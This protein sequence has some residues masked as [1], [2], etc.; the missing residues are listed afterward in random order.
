MIVTL[1]CDGTSWMIA[2]SLFG[3]PHGNEIAIIAWLIAT[4]TAVWI[5]AIASK[6]LA[7][8]IWKG[9]ARMQE[10][11]SEYKS[12][13]S[14][15]LP[16]LL[17]ISELASCARAAPDKW[18]NKEIL[19][20]LIDSAS[21]NH[22]RF[23]RAQLSAE[24]RLPGYDQDV[25][26]RTQGYQAEAWED[27]VHLWKLYNFHLFHIIEA[28]PMNKLNSICFIGQNEPVTLEFL[29]RDYVRHVKHHLE[30]IFA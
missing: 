27:L 23:V 7:R 22:Q 16:K 25:W 5:L 29:I 10:T 26:V 14:L 9:K 11:L 2:S 13:I 24:I 3:P 4:F 12:L 15:A 19:G 30:Q 18:S 20:H 21:N 1:H 6:W 28:I 8:K 17:T